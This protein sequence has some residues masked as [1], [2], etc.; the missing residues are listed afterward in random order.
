MYQHPWK[1]ITLGP[2]QHELLSV[3]KIMY[4]KKTKRL[5]FRMKYIKANKL[6]YYMKCHSANTV[7]HSNSSK[8]IEATLQQRPS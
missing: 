6:I 8:E 1:K 5:S 4:R 2:S 3:T 7:S